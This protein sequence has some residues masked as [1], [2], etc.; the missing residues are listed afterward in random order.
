M[1]WLIKDTKSVPSYCPHPL[2][3]PSSYGC[4]AIAI[5]MMVPDNQEWHTSYTVTVDYKHGTTAGISAYDRSLSVRKL[6]DPAVI[7]SD[8]T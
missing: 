4:I 5:P 6:I 7:P 3:P 8:F 1:A 2:T